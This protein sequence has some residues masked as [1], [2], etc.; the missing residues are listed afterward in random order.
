MSLKKTIRLWKLSKQNLS[1][2][3]E[4]KE[5]KKINEE[6]QKPNAVYFEPMNQD[7]FDTF[8]AEQRGWK[9]LFKKNG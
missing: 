9:K 2:E 1:L 7:Q 8:L 3:E 4:K 5:V 6:L